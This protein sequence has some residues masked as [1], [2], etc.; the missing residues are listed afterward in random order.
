MPNYSKQTLRRV[1]RLLNTDNTGHLRKLAEFSGLRPK[2]MSNWTVEETD[3][4]HRRMPPSAKRMIAMLA[5]FGAA[6]L[7]NEERMKDIKALEAALEE[8]QDVQKLLRRIR[9]IGQL[10]PSAPSEPASD[11]PEATT[12]AAL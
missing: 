10:R 5:Y 2:T 11:E 9:M 1:G 12:P 7:I 6:G 4:Q 8:E 3:P